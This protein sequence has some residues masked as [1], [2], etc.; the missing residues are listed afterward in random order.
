VKNSD[1]RWSKDW[2]L[3]AL[4]AVQRVELS[5][6]AFADQMCSQVQVRILVVVRG[7]WCRAVWEGGCHVARGAGESDLN[8]EPQTLWTLNPKPCGRMR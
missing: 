4:A 8:P 1:G 6:A 7:W 2:S 5:L 3:T